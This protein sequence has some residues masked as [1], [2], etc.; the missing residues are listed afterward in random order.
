MDLLNQDYSECHF[1]LD[2]TEVCSDDVTLIKLS[3]N[4]NI[5]SPLLTSIKKTIIDKLKS[6]TGCES[7]SCLYSTILVKNKLGRK[8]AKDVLNTRFKSKGPFNTDNWLSDSN[9]DNVLRQNMIKYKKFYAIPHQMIDFVKH[10]TELATINIPYILKNCNTIGVVLNTDVTDKK[11]G[12]KGGLHWFAI[13]IDAR[14]TPYTLE[15]F[16]SSGNLPVH[17]VQT[18]LNKTKRDLERSGKKT[19]IVV[20]SSNELQK[21]DTECGVFSLWFILSRV[22]GV[23]VSEFK[24][25]NMGPSDE[26]MLEFRKDLFRHS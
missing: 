18:W 25:V 3:D 8:Q 17:Q 15:F 5:N 21:S 16:N 14:R 11:D 19:E 12:G 23:N 20:V 13:F 9:I 1:A 6:D 7:E 10:K 22:K 26:K 24:N 2:K 4:Q